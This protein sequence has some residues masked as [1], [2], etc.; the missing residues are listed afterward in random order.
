MGTLVFSRGSW[1]TVEAAMLASCESPARDFVEA[2]NDGERAKIDALF[3]RLGDNGWITNV[4]KFKKIEGT[5]P[6]LYELKAF[7]IRMPCFFMGRRVVV[8]HGFKKKKDK[9]PTSELVRANR[10]RNEHTSREGAKK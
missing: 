2:L 1:G 10:I 5:S 9:M 6:A 3:R 8:T 4:E 7:Q